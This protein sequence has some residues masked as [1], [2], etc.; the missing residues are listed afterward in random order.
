MIDMVGSQTDSG[1][2]TLA[3]VL[4]PAEL[5]RHLSV[6]L[7][8]DISAEIRI[9]VL[10]WKKADRCTLEIALKRRGS[11]SASP[12]AVSLT[13]SPTDGWQE[14]IGKVYAE[15]RADVCRTM[16]E[17]R[18]AG[19][20][21][22]AEFGV[23]RAIAFIPSLRL[24]LYEKAPG[25]RARKVIAANEAGSAHAADRCARWL[26]EFHARGPRSGRV[27]A[28]SDQLRA[29][30][31]ARRVLQETGA[32]LAEK[33][34]RLFEELGWAAWRTGAGNMLASH[35]TYS[36]GQVLLAQERTLT[37]DWDTYQ[38]ADPA[39]DVARFLVELK[40]MGLKYTGSSTGFQAAADI[41]LSTYTATAGS[42]VVGR[43]AFQ[44]AAIFL[45]RAAHDVDKQADEKGNT[46]L[47]EGLRTLAAAT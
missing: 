41:F 40:R 8:W 2:P 17:I 13:A 47:D 4:D 42:G 32:P 15:D 45:D 14:L 9:K 20:E 29:L 25:V 24:L 37:I 43:L 21:P 18:Q 36:P 23:P 3:A 26:A 1:L 16:E 12:S 31:Q 22:D 7:Q 46:M 10:R 19:F 6:L 33:A 11:V 35:G 28:L 5:A 44:Q 30:E 27:F 34:N 39:F 38:V